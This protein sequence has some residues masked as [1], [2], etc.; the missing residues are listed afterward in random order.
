[1][2]A[3]FSTYCAGDLLQKQQEELRKLEEA[4]AQADAELRPRRAV[5]KRFLEEENQRREEG[6]AGKKQRVRDKVYQLN[7]EAK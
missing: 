4:K 1:M 7:M 3:R 6:K 5:E 2:V